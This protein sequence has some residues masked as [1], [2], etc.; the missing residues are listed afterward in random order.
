MLTV[1]VFLTGRFDIHSCGL[2]I[3]L[4]CLSCVAALDVL[5]LLGLC[6]LSIQSC[7]TASIGTFS[8]SRRH[9]IRSS[10]IYSILFCRPCD[11][12]NISHSEQS[13][14]LLRL[15]VLVTASIF[16]ALITFLIYW[17][18]LSPRRDHPCDSITDVLLSMIVTHSGTSLCDS[19]VLVTKLL[20]SRYVWL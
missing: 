18:S 5:V 15:I 6:T 7:L 9:C 8:K 12:I 10:C 4:T 11:G 14:T 17:G 3:L 16:V 19:N 13:C 2:K 20:L 1:S